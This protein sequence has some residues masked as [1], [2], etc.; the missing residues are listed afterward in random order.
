MKPSLTGKGYGAVFVES[1]IS[2]GRALLEF[3]HLELIVVDF[4][5]RARKVYE[6]IGF[7]KIGEIENDIRGNIYNFIIMAKDWE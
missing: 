3:N 2:Q 5:I 7:I 1:I 6:K 4:N